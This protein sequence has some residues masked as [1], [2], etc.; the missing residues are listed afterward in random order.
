MTLHVTSG[1][2]RL[3]LALALLTT[4]LWG[5]L[6]IALR[7][8]LQAV[9]LYTI[10]WF[11]FSVAF[12][13]LFLILALQRKLP[14]FKKLTTQYWILLAI[15][16]VFLACNYGFFMQG[17]AMTSPANSQVLIQLSMVFF[18]FGALWIYRERYNRWQWAGVG[19]LMLGF[20]LFFNDQLRALVH[21]SQ[22]Y[23]LGSASLVIAA[24]A[25]A[26]YALAQKQLLQIWS[27][28]NIMLIIYGGSALLFLPLANPAQLGQLQPLH[29]ATLIF[30]ALN[31]LVAYGAFAESLEHWEASRVSAVLASTPIVTL[32]SVTATASIWPG[33]LRPEQ[34]SA[35]GLIG[36]FCVVGGSLL[37]SLGQRNRGVK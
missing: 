13:G 6:P 21:A 25:W 4:T 33:L 19:L 31:T 30:C 27:S 5:V 22:T 15:A 24:A 14:S 34:I 16:C 35:L 9:D 12:L 8:T 11:R 36:A 23:L 32:I 29:W 2:W 7:V 10:I 37:V 18:G 20:S 1:R 26:V 17:L 28:A 3:G